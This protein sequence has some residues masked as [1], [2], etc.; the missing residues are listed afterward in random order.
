MSKGGPRIIFI[1]TEREDYPRNAQILKALSRGFET[2]KIVSNKP[3]YVLRIAEVTLRFI[4]L[5]VLKDYQL[6][7][8]GFL[9]QPLVPAIRLFSKK[10]LILDA[11]VSVYDVL[12]LDRK[13]F[14]PNSLIGRL[15]F[16]LDKSSLEKSDKI[17]AD[18]NAGARFLSATFGIEPLKFRTL[19]TGLNEDMFYPRE[20]AEKNDKFTV[21]YHGT[22][23][24][25]HGVDYIIKAAKLIETEKD[26]RLQ[27]LGTGREKKKILE[28]AKTARAGNVE[29]IDWVSYQ[30]LACRIASSDICLGGHFSAADKAKRVI[31]GKTFMYLAMKKP[32]VIADNPASQEL[33]SHRV[34]GYL[35]RMADA[36]SLAEAIVNLKNDA[37]LRDRIAAAGFN[38]YKNTC[39][40]E[41]TKD[42]L[43][44]VIKDLTS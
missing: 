20:P 14:K 31:S 7:Y 32:V 4:F 17:I 9:G 39:C 1:C 40:E 2:I 44:S 33:F 22:F 30:D 27:I 26:I 11:F 35:C 13:D 23:W 29:F 5:S 15:A 36:K 8:A 41:K 37:G 19:Y 43:I 34:N 10:P 18:T 25:L 16:F 3:S 38:L 28:L 12:A 21:F 42:K 24:P 6:I